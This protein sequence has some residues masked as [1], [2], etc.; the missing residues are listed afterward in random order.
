MTDV[1]LQA[2]LIK[3]PPATKEV[4]GALPNIFTALCL[5]EAGLNE[6]KKYD[7]FD[8]MFKVLI[9]Q[10]Y[11]Q[12]M[13]RRRT[14]ESVND[15]AA[16]LGSSVDE[17]MRHQNSLRIPA[18]KAVIK[19]L[20]KLVEL[21]N[22]PDIVCIK[23]G[24]TPSGASDSK[25]HS[26]RANDLIRSPSPPAEIVEVESQSD[27]DT[28]ETI[29]EMESGILVA[30]EVMTNSEESVKDCED[31]E[32]APKKKR[33]VPLMDYLINVCKFLDT[34]LSNNNTPDHCKAFIQEGGLPV[35]IQLISLRALPI[36]F[37]SS[38]AANQIA[39]V[40]R[41]IL[42]LSKDKSV[43]EATLQEVDSWLDIFR[44]NR[45]EAGPLTSE[46]PSL[47]LRELIS[48]VN[49]GRETNSMPIFRCLTHIHSFV[50]LFQN[51]TTNV[52]PEVRTLCVNVW[53]GVLGLA[54]MSKFAD[55]YRI[56]IWESTIM[57][58]LIEGSNTEETLG[59]VDFERLIVK[60]EYLAS[61][62]KTP[63]PP[64]SKA[65]QPLPALPTVS[66]GNSASPTTENLECEVQLMEIGSPEN[67]NSALVA[68]S[69]LSNKSELN[70]KI[71]A[72][73][74]RLIKMIPHEIAT[75]LGAKLSTLFALFV[76]MS[77]GGSV[78]PRQSGFSRNNITHVPTE[79]ARSIADM[80]ARHI[81]DTL[82]W[83]PPLKSPTSRFRFSFFTCAVQ[84]SSQLLMDDVRSPYH[85]MLQHLLSQRGE[86]VLESSLYDGVKAATGKDLDEILAEDELPPGCAEYLA[87]WL[88][89]I[90][91][92]I[93]T[94]RILESRYGLPV[95]YDPDQYHVPFRPGR[96]LVTIH[97]I[98]FTAVKKLWGKNA[99]KGYTPKPNSPKLLETLL[100]VLRHI[101][102]SEEQIQ[103]QVDKENKE[104]D[105]HPNRLMEA[106]KKRWDTNPSKFGLDPFNV[107]HMEPSGN[108]PGATTSAATSISALYQQRQAQLSA[109]LTQRGL[110]D[111][112]NDNM[113]VRLLT[114]QL[115]AAIGEE[116]G[117][118]DS[119]RTQRQPIDPTIDP[120]SN[121]MQLLL[122]DP[123]V[124]PPTGPT[125]PPIYQAARTTQPPSATAT[126]TDA[127]RTQ[128][129]EHVDILVRMG[130]QSRLAT[131]ALDQCR[132]SLDQA[133]E[134]C[135]QHADEDDE[136]E[137]AIQ[138][139]LEPNADAA[140]SDE[141]DAM[142][143]QTATQ[144]AAEVE[145]AT[146]KAAKEAEAKRI[147]DEIKEKA[148]QKQAAH[149]QKQIA[150]Q[151]QLKVDNEIK[152]Q[153]QEAKMKALDQ[154]RNI[155]I[156]KDEITKFSYN[157]I[158][159]CLQLLDDDP[160]T[161]YRI[162]DL[163][164][165]TIRR[166]GQAWMKGR[167]NTH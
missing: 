30:D 158:G 99:L 62:P 110:G 159:G 165:V 122:P 17:L 128:R 162:S 135:I 38:Q 155:P 127:A 20:N 66:F 115:N 41:V 39:Q 148:A 156:T 57:I 107:E 2:L 117:N 3:E 157:M 53:G 10:D 59:R 45:D 161:V 1:I 102:K 143:E 26:S 164:I 103:K 101:I 13:K 125:T 90:E 87:E 75:Q 71:L 14:S 104:D 112:V 133:A 27:D 51:M 108:R 69:A 80:L 119:A 46:S 5:N 22:D 95:K 78:R 65:E 98:A 54:V 68:P 166:N 49:E 141:E 106:V 147:E 86:K 19:L 83:E 18:I 97:Q 114:E 116:S 29:D 55:L 56:L 79:S 145:A 11:L 123:A 50:G 113:E 37:P 16:V 23:V 35:L 63:T 4:L 146:L 74:Q 24:N 91:K 82:M 93:D 121:A 67:S 137:M 6:F 149:K 36:E 48:S 58:E 151:K 134:Y 136:L 100:A 140:R 105:D 40:L 25:V 42:I 31:E 167:I 64:R 150:A 120:Y 34:M 132:N 153:R 47:L 118:V 129:Q 84:L 52:Q 96:Y 85:L 131:R 94:S 88:F 124:R 28:E 126:M 109:L 21:G 154:S 138:M 15:T 92:L 7:P 76:K 160:D 44:A 70:E 32:F 60:D 81:N 142:P 139:S 33:E 9:N 61:I 73:K 77:V 163:L 152:R 8:K 144:L 12:A 111:T 72:A 89:L 130:Y 43:L